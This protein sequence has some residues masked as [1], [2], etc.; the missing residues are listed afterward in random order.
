METYSLTHFNSLIISN[1]QSKIRFWENLLDQ[2]IDMGSGLSTY[3][4]KFTRD[5]CLKSRVY[6]LNFGFTIRWGNILFFLGVSSAKFFVHFGGEV[7]G[8]LLLLLIGGFRTAGWRC[9][10]EWW[11]I[12]TFSLSHLYK[13][14]L[15]SFIKFII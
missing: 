8:F 4:L 14:Y 11:V 1:L 7:K 15:K 12:I 5:R 10:V 13:I 9:L 6:K 3:L 2:D